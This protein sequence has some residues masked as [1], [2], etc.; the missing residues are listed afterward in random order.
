M[1]AYNFF[2]VRAVFG[3]DAVSLFS[4]SESYYPID[5][6][7]V[8]VSPVLASRKMEARGWA[9]FQFLVAKLLIVV[10]TCGEV[11]QAVSGSDL[12]GS[13]G[14]TQRLWQWQKQDLHVPRGV[15]AT[16]GAWL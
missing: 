9:N 4:V 8:S 5:R 11:V 14:G 2:G 1:R 16:G 10:R 12:Q 13:V 6:G 15:R 7:C 3:L